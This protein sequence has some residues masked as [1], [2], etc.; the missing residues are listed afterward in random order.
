MPLSSISSDMSK[1]G[2]MPNA[3]AILRPLLS[4]GSFLLVRYSLIVDNGIPVFSDRYA[5]VTSFSL[6]ISLNIKIIFPPYVLIFD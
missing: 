3:S 5:D 4:D 2:S 1:C 6:Q